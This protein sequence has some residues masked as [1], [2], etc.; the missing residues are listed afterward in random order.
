MTDRQGQWAVVT[1]ASSGI[2]RAVARELANE[3]MNLVL[4]ARRTERLAELASTLAVKALTFG[5]DFEQPDGARRLFEFT[6]ANTV[7]PALLVNNAGF[8]TY[9]EFRETDP[10]RQ[11]AMVQ[12][13]CAAVVA[14]THLYLPGM[15]ER[16]SGD[17]LIV[18]STAAFQ[19]VPYQTTYAATKAFDLIFA[20]G[21]AQEVKRFGIRV[22]ALC[23]GQTRSE[24]HEIA[25]EPIPKGMSVHSA[26]EVAQIG[27][28]ALRKGKH[29]VICG[30]SNR[31]GM[32]LGRIAPRRVV[33]AVSE[34][35]FRPS[36]LKTGN[37]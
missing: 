10:Y 5:V 24:F 11:M 32:E 22:C 14:L 16:R 35:L 9:G 13:N 19:A 26:E 27:L 31:L 6:E 33:T 12:V 23:P 1:G 20:E 28:R 15:I 25:Q 18:A 4:A 21:L 3:G 17:I 34:R 30:F 7:R 2:G 29:Q 8:G 37:R 36:H